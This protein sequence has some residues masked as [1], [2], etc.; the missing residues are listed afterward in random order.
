[1]R[2]LL[3][4]PEWPDIPGNIHSTSA[5]RFPPLALGILAAYSDG[6]EVE[7]VDGNWE[8]I[9]FHRRYDLVGISTTTFVSDAAYE[10]ARRFRQRGAKVVLG[11]VHPTILP[12]EALEHADAVVVGEAE[13]VWGDVLR[14]TEQGK[15]HGIYQ[16]EHPT[17]MNKIRP[18][19]RDYLD[20]LPWFTLVEATRGCT[21]KCRYCYLPSTPWA[22]HRMRPVE[23]V[24]AEIRSL[25]QRMFMFTDDNLFADRE[26]AL[27]LLKG[28]APLGKFW[29]VQAP[30]TL[31]D[32]APLLDAM[33]AAGCFNA[34]VG[35]QSLNAKS[36]EAARVS[37]NRVDKYHRLVRQFQ[38]RGIGVT[39]FFLF[40]FDTDGPDVF[41]HTVQ[42]IKS[43][44]VDDAGL[45]I[46]TPF[47]GTKF[48]AQLAREGRLLDEVRPTQYC[49]TKAIFQPKQMTP[50]ELEQGLRWT[51]DQLHPVF[52]RRLLRACWIHRRVLLAAPQMA[53]ALIAGNLRQKAPGRARRDIVRRFRPATRQV[54]QEGGGS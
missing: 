36:L 27:R 7:V 10:A 4:K 45:F 38:S 9:P 49:W 50:Q 1:M 40:G 44:K 46:V 15:L 25:P 13:Q 3:M 17:D 12:E 54:G 41:R 33:A 16:A 5:A 22:K 21:N 39:G 47:P 14:D 6:H 19:K 29:L 52:S 8:P 43:M 37:H 2:V 28:I 31:V 51:F 11:G 48:H 20:E 53:L 26:Y 23:Q 18:A 30:T 34:H 32:D 35:F 42:M 24:V